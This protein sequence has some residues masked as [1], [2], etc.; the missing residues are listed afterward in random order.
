MTHAN[1]TSSFF[2][3]VPPSEPTEELDV[4]LP[5]PIWSGPP[6]HYRPGVVGFSQLIGYSESTAV[7]IEGARVYPEGALLRLAVRVRETARER[8]RRLF[9]QLEFTHGRGMLN[10]G[11]QPGGLRWGL[12]FA[13][14]SRVTTLDAGPWRDAPPGGSMEWTPKRPA[15]TGLGRPAESFDTWSREMW[16]WPLPPKGEV[17]VVCLWPDRGIEETSTSFDANI[18]LTAAERATP[19]WPAVDS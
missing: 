9:A 17:R 12:E 11:L 4:P 10:M 13:D 7:L 18:I 3:P 1:P 6:W 5:G 14:G 8:R 19:L 15:L 16:L 2:P